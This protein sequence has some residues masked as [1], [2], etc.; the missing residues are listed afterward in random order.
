MDTNYKNGLYS[1]FCMVFLNLRDFYVE[2]FT[3][4][5]LGIVGSN[6]LHKNS[7]L[8]MMVNLIPYF[9]LSH[10]FRILN[11]NY[12][13]KTDDLIGFS[14][15]NKT[16][17]TPVLLGAKL[18]KDNETIDIKEIFSKYKNNVPVYVIFDNEKMNVGNNDKVY[19]KFIKLGKIQEKEFNLKKIKSSLKLDLF[20]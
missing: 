4:R 9:F 2:N 3:T 15:N 11:Y 5:I 17:L 20:N 10:V 16:T 1:K 13:Y 14:E 18:I 8:L 6:K 7:I 19:L 12:I